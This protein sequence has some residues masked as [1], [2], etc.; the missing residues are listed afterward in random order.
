MK[1]YCTMKFTSFQNL[2]GKEL[3]IINTSDRIIVACP[4]NSGYD[5][6][7]RL[8]ENGHDYI[9]GG[10]PD[11][12]E[13]VEKEPIKITN[14]NEFWFDRLERLIE[15]SGEITNDGPDRSDKVFKFKMDYRE[16]CG[17]DIDEERLGAYK[18]GKNKKNA[19]VSRDFTCRVKIYDRPDEYDFI[20][21]V[22]DHEV[23]VSKD[24]NVI[25]FSD[26]ALVWALVRRGMDFFEKSIQADNVLDK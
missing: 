25:S 18:V 6:T 26:T 16:A 23:K 15:E 19:Q 21:S 4:H 10:C 13:I 9:Y 12:K 22:T 14:A 11:C 1:G 8:E 7:F 17:R 5:V 3:E 20:K 24:G 2:V